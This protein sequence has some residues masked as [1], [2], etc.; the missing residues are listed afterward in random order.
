MSYP[1]LADIT[2]EGSSGVVDVDVADGVSGAESGSGVAGVIMSI[3]TCV[4][5]PPPTLPKECVHP[6]LLPSEERRGK[7]TADAWVVTHMTRDTTFVICHNSLFN[8][9]G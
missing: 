1:H 2:T 3:G 8:L 6:G 7:S 5:S 4:T 9:T